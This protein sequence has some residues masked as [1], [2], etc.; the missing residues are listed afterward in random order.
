MKKHIKVDVLALI[1]GIE[2][3]YQ[4]KC[5]PEAAQ[6]VAQGI[7]DQVEECFK[8]LPAETVN[9]HHRRVSAQ[10]SA[11]LKG[12]VEQ[13]EVMENVQVICESIKA[14]K[15]RADVVLCPAFILSANGTKHA[16]MIPPPPARPASSTRPAPTRPAP[17][18]KT[19]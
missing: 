11:T 10:L 9:E 16:A 2:A 8:D 3:A 7:Y 19:K 6:V 12:T 1:D 5:N 13:Q 17:T 4:A 14:E 18:R 15:I